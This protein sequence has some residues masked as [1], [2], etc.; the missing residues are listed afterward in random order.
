MTE[1][2]SLSLLILLIFVIS[3]ALT[4]HF[5]Q[6]SVGRKKAARVAGIFVVAGVAI[7]IYGFYTDYELRT[8][9][10]IEAMLEGTAGFNDGDPAPTRRLPFV[11]EHAGV[12]HDLMI[13]PMRSSAFQSLG[14]VSMEIVVADAQGDLLID[15]QRTFEVRTDR[16]SLSSWDAFYT[17]FTPEAIGSHELSLTLLSTD[18]E[19]VHVRIGDPMKHDGSR[20]PGY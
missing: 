5:G 10:L 19:R 12:T 9:T 15:S 11:V 7:A 4:W 2:L 17:Q 3:G 14:P 6:R 13:A 16:R 8:T 18:I 1:S 20:I